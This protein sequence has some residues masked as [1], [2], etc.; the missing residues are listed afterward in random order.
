VLADDT[1]GENISQSVIVASHKLVK[2]EQIA[3]LRDAW[4]EAADMVNAAPEDFRALLAEKANLNDSIKGS[5]PISTYPHANAES[6]SGSPDGKGG[7]Y[8]PASLI[9]P[10]IEWMQKKGY[11]GERVVY[12]ETDGSLSVA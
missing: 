1:K 3:G 8:P 4:D 5:Y 2:D 10:Q 12:N 7:A 9:G 6:G 11:G